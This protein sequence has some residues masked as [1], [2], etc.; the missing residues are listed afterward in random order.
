M[1]MWELSNPFVKGKSMPLMP[2]DDRRIMLIIIVSGSGSI[3]M[4]AAAEV[5]VLVS[6]QRQ[7]F[8]CSGIIAAVEVLA[9][10]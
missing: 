1:L 6:H 9:V 5:T 4:Q 3:S 8:G 7:Y 10:S 2:L